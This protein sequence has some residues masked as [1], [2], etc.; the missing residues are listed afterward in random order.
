MRNCSFRAV[1]KRI[2]HNS[3]KVV[4]NQKNMLYTHILVRYGEVFLKGKNKSF[5]EKKL[6]EN[7]RK[8]TG[9][10]DV[11]S[12]QSR[13]IMPFFPE[14]QRLQRV[15]GLV[16]YSPIQCMERN[17]EK[18]KMIA[19]DLVRGAKTFRIDASRSDKSFPLT[20]PE[21]NVAVGD[22]VVEQT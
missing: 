3:F 10:Q 1:F 14:H 22:Y 2:K 19:V 18:V 7:I 9:I 20:S 4:Q 8:I 11:V 5:F 12:H 6:R 21:I 15:F 16:S 17:L 13:I